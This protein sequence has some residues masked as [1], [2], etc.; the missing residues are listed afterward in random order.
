MTDIYR[1]AASRLHA[2]GWSP[3]PLTGKGD[4][5]KGEDPV[6][7]GF[8]G[9]TGIDPSAQQVAQWESIKPSHNI[10]LRLPPD[11]CGIDVDDYVKG[12]EV[13]QGLRTLVELEGKWGP[14]PATLMS[15]SRTNGSGI[16]FFRIPN[17]TK[18]AT[19]AGIDIDVIQRTH[20]Y[21]VVAPSIHPEG[22]PYRFIE[23]ATGVVVDEPWPIEDLPPLPDYWLDGLKRGERLNPQ[24][25]A[26]DEQVDAF[27]RENSRSD[28]PQMLAGLKSLLSNV[29]KTKGKGRHDTLVHCATQA[30]VEVVAGAYTLDEAIEVL[31]EWWLQ[32]IDDPERLRMNPHTGQSEFSLAI[33]W[34]IPQATVNAERVTAVRHQIDIDPLAGFVSADHTT[35]GFELWSPTDERL[36]PQPHQDLFH[37]HIGQ[38][39]LEASRYSEADPVAIFAQALTM[40]GVAANRTAYLSAGNNKHTAALF[41]LVIGATAKARKGTSGA[42]ARAL[43]TKVEPALFERSLSG[44]GSGEAIIAELA[45]VDEGQAGPRDTRALIY[46]NEFGSLLS[47]ASRQGSIISETI[48]NAWDGV[49]LSNRTRS[50]GRI[51]AT[52]YHLGAIGHITEA[53]FRSKL[54]G[55]D[56]HNGMVNRWLMVH[57]GRGRLMPDGGNVPD[58]LLD[59][60]AALLKEN[61][62]Q[63]WHTTI[64]QRTPEAKKLWADIY[65]Q[66]A[67]DDPPGALGGVTSRG[68]AQTLRLSIALALADGSPF[69]AAEH[70]A[71]AFK[72]WNYCRATAA[73]VFGDST[74]NADADRLLEA[75]R[76][77]RGLGLTATAQ[78]DLFSK[79]KGRADNARAL[80]EREGLA[81]SI[82]KPTSGAPATITY[83][84][85]KPKDDNLLSL[86]S[87][88]S[89]SHNEHTEDC[90][91]GISDVVDRVSATKATEEIQDLLTQSSAPATEAT[92]EEAWDDVKLPDIF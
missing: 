8:T 3:L 88:R 39:A 52:G 56:V 1:G 31:N 79:H 75:L 9:Y 5:T 89:Q 14:L 11:V 47:A 63:A 12:N 46:E 32:V 24:N 20:R 67:A 48:R 69:I 25:A 2:E 81:A 36:R 82:K 55:A 80:L 57:A 83:A 51:I 62:K 37:G 13:K 58:Y 7:I 22:R 87:L 45:G 64:M 18:L 26:S 54:T 59:K 78:R 70:V 10:A 16:R 71:A 23:Q 72:I 85:A 84:I 77:A 86:L 65:G 21:V 40:F 42:V 30:M 73:H 4:G 68:D 28:A 50:S 38:F 33:A 6:P 49:P 35:L 34:A 61:L 91:D 66:I 29:R 76:E 90:S 41:V 15:T 19:V 17:G 53:E 74:G 43:M 92:E 60:Y 44:F 27:R